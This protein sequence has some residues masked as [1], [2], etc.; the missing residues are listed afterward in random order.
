MSALFRIAGEPD[1]EHDYVLVATLGVGFCAR[2]RNRN[3]VLLIPVEDPQRAVA[4]EQPP[5][6]CPNRGT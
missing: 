5:C 4:S 3:V 6:A 1:P 2:A